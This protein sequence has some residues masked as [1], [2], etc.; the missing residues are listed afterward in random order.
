[1]EKV[2]DGTEVVVGKF[3]L[4]QHA[5]IISVGKSCKGKKWEFI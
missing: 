5:K 4:V 3:Y 1:M 2:E